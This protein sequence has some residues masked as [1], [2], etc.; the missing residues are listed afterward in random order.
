M[1][2]QP[3]AF[4]VG[5]FTGRVLFDGGGPRNLPD[6]FQDAS[7]DDLQTVVRMHGFDPS[8]T[9]FSRNILL[10]HTG[11]D[12]VLVD[13]GQGIDPLAEKLAAAGVPAESISLIII[14]H[15]HFDHIGGIFTPDGAFIYPNARYA[16]WQGEWDFWTDE[17]RLA[18]NENNP[19]TAMLRRLKAHANMVTLIDTER[20]IIPSISAV[21]L[22][23]HTPGQM[24]LLIE[25]N[26]ETLLHIADAAHAIPQISRPEW[27]PRFDSD[28][29]QAAQTRAA[30][31]ERIIRQNLRVQ[32]YHFPFP[33][34][35]T[36]RE[37]GSARTWLPAG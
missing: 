25:S 36:I 33:G 1:T 12:T 29:A 15:C 22:P 30:V 28:K 19:G 6:L 7:A 8:A 32:A 37:A 14:T 23:G 2:E 9:P 21:A 20:E 13:T 24:G 35:G 31:F 34:Q 26:G 27:S 11:S 17:A 4:Q 16:M 18:A 3:F 10:L 5:S